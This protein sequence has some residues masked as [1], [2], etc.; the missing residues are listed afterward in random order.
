M[1]KTTGWVVALS[2]VVAALALIAAIVFGVVIADAYGT[3][4]N[5]RACVAAVDSLRE[6]RAAG[7]AGPELSVLEV[8]AERY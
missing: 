5:D 1:T 7:T 4:L 3:V 2:A 6:Q 8:I